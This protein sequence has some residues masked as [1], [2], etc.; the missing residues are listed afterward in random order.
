MCLMVHDTSSKNLAVHLYSTTT[1]L[2]LSS[3][4]NIDEV[5]LFQYELFGKYE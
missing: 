1:H 2:N 5:Q 4:A 3:I